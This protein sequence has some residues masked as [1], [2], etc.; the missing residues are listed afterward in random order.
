MNDTTE[1]TRTVTADNQCEC[2]AA[3]GL[4][5]YESGEATITA[6]WVGPNQDENGDTQVICT[7]CYEADVGAWVRE[8]A[9]AALAA[10]LATRDAGEDDLREAGL[11]PA[12]GDTDDREALESAAEAAD[13]GLCVMC[14]HGGGSTVTRETQ[15]VPHDFLGTLWR[16]RG[17]SSCDCCGG[18]TVTLHV[19]TECQ[20][21]GGRHP[22]PDACP[23]C[24]RADGA[25]RIR[26]RLN[27]DEVEAAGREDADTYLAELTDNETGNRRS[28]TLEDLDSVDPDWAGISVGQCGHNWWAEEVFPCLDAAALDR[29]QVDALWSILRRPWCEAYNR[30]AAERI[31]EERAE[32]EADAQGGAA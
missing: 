6:Q 24:W 4:E 10:I 3:C 15:E 5:P 22:D 14:A 1:T 31:A 8:G 2:C 21:A 20:D 32:L 19:C 12:R 25:Q 9:K 28:A 7:E 17:T 29:R 18:A 23:V 26:D 30:G 13:A 11:L 27:E 16:S